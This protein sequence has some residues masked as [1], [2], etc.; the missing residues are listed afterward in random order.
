V[1]TTGKDF[2]A[3]TLEMAEGMWRYRDYVI[4]SINHDKPWDRFLTEQIA[5]DE[6]VD[7]RSAK[8]LNP[9]MIELLTATGYLHSILDITWDDIENLPINRF[10]ALFKLVEK[11]SSSTMGLTMGCA[12]CHTH[13][14]DPIPQ[15]D[16]YRFV[17][18]FT[19][20]Y[21]P[22]A[23]IKPKDRYLWPVSK[24][25]KEEIDRH[26][27]EID[28][29]VAELAKQLAAERK[30]YEE[31]LLNEKLKS[32]PEVIR[33]DAK[34]ALETPKEKRD[35]VQKFLFTKFGASLDVKDTEVRKSFTEADKAA[36]EKL[37]AQIQTW[38]GYRTKLDKIEAVW[39]TG[40]PPINRLLQRG[41]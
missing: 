35:E 20:A 22:N 2:D 10:E 17:S 15:R 27:A 5:G 41:S 13:K 9:K 28:K 7:W 40:A 4:E 6:M 1:D 37:E 23:W 11:V 30:P 24:E 21:N 19:T 34:L 3:K 38:N 32:L 29:P 12:R 36:V 16:Y 31:R 18:L 14:F 8:H 39:D 33:G 25:D 26:N